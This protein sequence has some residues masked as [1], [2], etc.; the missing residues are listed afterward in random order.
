MRRTNRSLLIAAILGFGLFASQPGHAFASLSSTGQQAQPA[1]VAP[2]APA[3]P[4][5]VAPP[6]V[7]APA[8]GQAAQAAQQQRVAAKQRAMQAAMAKRQAEES[9]KAAR[10]AFV[11]GVIIGV[12]AAR[13]R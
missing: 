12:L 1:A 6:A 13:R 4:V 5:V 11:G 3:P 9:R 2:A 8:A 10:R 7:A